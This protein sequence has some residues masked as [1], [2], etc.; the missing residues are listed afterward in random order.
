VEG[1]SLFLLMRYSFYMVAVT[2]GEILSPFSDE[3]AEKAE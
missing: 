1:H 3:K 2:K